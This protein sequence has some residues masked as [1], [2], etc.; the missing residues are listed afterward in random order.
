[1]N[2]QDEQ[3]SVATG[4]T[5]PKGNKMTDEDKKF[6]FAVAALIGLTARGASVQEIKDTLWQLATLAV[7]GEPK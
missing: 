4:V 2:W 7:E 6:T 3:K 5:Q 1:M